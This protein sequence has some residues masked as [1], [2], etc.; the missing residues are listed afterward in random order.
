MKRRN[1]LKNSLS[2]S[3]VAGA[4]SILPGSNILASDI[5]KPN[6]SKNKYNN[7]EFLEWDIARMRRSMESGDL[8]SYKLTKAYLKRIEELN[9]T[10]PDLKAVIAVNP[11]AEDQARQRDAER[12]AGKTKGPMHGIPVLI[13]DNINTAGMP[14]T[15]GS[16]ALSN[17]T[18]GN[19]FIINKLEEAGAVILGKA[20][21][22]EWANFRSVRSSSGWS[23]VGG[24]CKNPYSLD[25]SPCGSSSGSGVAVAA[26]MCAVAIGT[27][28]NG[29]IICPSGINGVV[30]IKPTVGLWSREGIIPI[31]HTQD[32]AG[33]IA[34]TVSDAVALLAACMGKDPNDPATQEMAIDMNFDDA[35]DELS[36]KDARLGVAKN[37]MGKHKEVDAAMEKSIL[38][39]QEAGAQ[40][41]EIDNILGDDIDDAEM[42][43][44]LYE[45]KDGLN[46]YL[47]TYDA[48]Y[49]SLAELIEYNKKNESS[50]L[51]W[52][53]QEIFEMAEKKGSLNDQEYL[54]ALVKI[55]TNTQKKGIDKYME[56]HDLDAIVMPTNAPAWTIDLLL[57]DHGYAG[58]SGAAAMSG[59]PNIT[60]PSGDIH[61]MPVGISFVGR[62]WSEKKLIGLAY[63]FEQLTNK[64]M[65]PQY[66]ESVSAQ[67]EE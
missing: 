59:Y 25:R 60:V 38:A 21:L 19:A 58:S 35:L 18:P 24:Q 7:F 29:S 33:P 66:R 22:S 47:K 42:T 5:Q 37:Y 55:R 15:A 26:N 10:G 57:G 44:L 43:V 53:G 4:L 3:V 6:T 56:E 51:K 54:D 13:K 23:G 12:V 36:L 50:E 39:I 63:A 20:N 8:T 27:E 49:K 46:R 67:S 1:F 45:F 32:T 9:H 28:T 14:T 48:P 64:R 65:I 62:A 52:F 41:I 30:G 61:G 40:I 34:R 2:G 31:S 17:H 11:K 16:L